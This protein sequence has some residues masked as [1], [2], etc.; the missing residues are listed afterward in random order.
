MVMQAREDRNVVSALAT[1]IT[2]IDTLR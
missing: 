2:S 1:L